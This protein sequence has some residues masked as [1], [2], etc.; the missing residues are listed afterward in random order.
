MVWQ[1]LHYWKCSF[2]SIAVIKRFSEHLWDPRNKRKRRI[3]PEETEN[4]SARKDSSPSKVEE[5]PVESA[6]NGTTST[7][8]KAPDS[9]SDDVSS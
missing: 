5:S 7:T 9:S 6:D 8:T 4:D 1:T 2:N 3:K